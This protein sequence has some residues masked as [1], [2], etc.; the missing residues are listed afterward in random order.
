MEATTTDSTNPVERTDNNG[1]LLGGLRKEQEKPIGEEKTTPIKKSVAPVIAAK[2]MRQKAAQSRDVDWTQLW[3]SQRIDALLPELDPVDHG[4]SYSVTCPSCRQ[5][6]EAFVYKNNQGYIECNRKNGCKAV[7]NV[8]DYIQSREN[9]ASRWDT[10]VYLHEQA[11][12]ELPRMR[13]KTDEEVK[14]DLLREDFWNICRNHLCSSTEE[15]PSEV[16]QYL[17]KRKMTD[18]MIQHFGHY[19]GKQIMREEMEKRGHDWD[20]VKSLYKF[21]DRRD[22]HP[23]VFLTETPDGAMI[24]GRRIDSQKDKKYL[25]FGQY[26]KD[27]PYNAGRA[28]RHLNDG[29]KLLIVEGNFDA[30]RIDSHGIPVIAATSSNIPGSYIKYL[31]QKKVRKV[32]LLLDTDAAGQ[33]GTLSSIDALLKAGID[34]EVIPDLPG[35]KDPDEYIATQGIAAFREILKD[36]QQWWQYKVEHSGVLKKPF[37]EKK[38]ALIEIFNQIK[39]AAEREKASHWFAEQLGIAPES[40]KTDV[41]S[42]LNSKAEDLLHSEEAGVTP[43]DR[44]EYVLTEHFGYKF[45]RD[46][47]RDRIF[48][49]G[50]PIDDYK[51]SEIYLQMSDIGYKSENRV[52]HL[53]QRIANRNGYNPICDYLNGLES[54][55]EGHIEALAA[56]F[57]TDDDEW[58]R[59]IFRKFLIGAVTRAFQEVQPPML[60][61]SGGQGAGKSYFA[62]WLCSGIPDNFHDGI[63]L[64]KDKDHIYRLSHTFIWEVAELGATTKKGDKEDL[65]LFLT[66]TS[67]SDLRR[68]YHPDPEDKRIYTSF[69]GTVNNFTGFLDD[70]TGSRRFNITEVKEID[71]GYSQNIDVN[72][73]WAEAYAAYKAGETW[74]LTPDEEEKRNAINNNYEMYSL[75]GELVKEKTVYTGNKSDWIPSAKIVRYVMEKNRSIKERLAQSEAKKALQDIGCEIGKRNGLSGYRGCKFN[76]ITQD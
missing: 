16:M 37:S 20:A 21:A 22:E 3:R 33:T 25:P 45:S 10:V 32:V 7:T 15:E 61:L 43:S 57:T 17:G 31:K 48:V 59:L 65:K 36:P 70:P 38:D 64:P 67:V 11:G 41:K 23:L 63:I 34:V 24:I 56:H 69:I 27:I 54:V 58:F 2:P 50:E 73:V 66:C 68:S 5:K 29:Q 1:S 28:L 13:Q 35:A 39:G 19:P 9:H 60:V 49:N 4:S 52:K 62:R 18:G 14:A 72:T 30:L 74:R 71:H 26:K 53:I 76:G 51:R 12:L 47:L 42:N 55:N 40:F 46:T 6:K 44:A 8:F 75:T